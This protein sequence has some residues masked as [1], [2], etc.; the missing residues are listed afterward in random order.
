[1]AVEVGICDRQGFGQIC[2]MLLG[3][4]FLEPG[5]AH[6]VDIVLSPRCTPIGMIESGALHLGEALS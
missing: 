3:N 2:G 1:L 4:E 6:H 5:T